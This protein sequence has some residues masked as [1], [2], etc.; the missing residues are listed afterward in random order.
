LQ[1][2]LSLSQV[3]AAGKAWRTAALDVFNDARFFRSSPAAG[4]QWR[5]LVSRLMELDRDRLQE[6]L[7]ECTIMSTQST[8]DL[9]RIGATP[10]ANIFTNREAEMIA[11]STNLRRLSFIL[12]SSDRDHY[13]TQL[14]GIQEKLVD[15]LRTTI[16][17]PMVHSE[18]RTAKGSGM[19]LTIQVYLC[20]RVLL[21]RLSPQ[22]LAN[23]WPVILAELVRCEDGF[24]NDTDV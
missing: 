13:V 9:G 22:Y 16:V 3:S 11:R 24:V 6:F 21:C 20:L 12:Y 4:S 5:P 18:V 1:L 15:I 17:S 14:P 2:L 8:D 7:G 23:F 10:S 19:R